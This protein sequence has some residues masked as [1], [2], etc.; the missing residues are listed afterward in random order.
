MALKPRRWIISLFY[1]AVL[2]IERLRK[3]PRSRNCLAS[4][5]AHHAEIKISCQVISLKTELEV[6]TTILV[7]SPQEKF[8]PRQFVHPPVPKP[9]P[10]R[11]IYINHLKTPIL[12]PSVSLN[13]AISV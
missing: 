4:S 12:F 7:P 8:K 9:S 3:R 10:H 13:S 11:S 2:W 6:K 5:G 1:R